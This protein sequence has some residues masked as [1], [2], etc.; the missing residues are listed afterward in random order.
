L[1]WL[2]EVAAAL[3]TLIQTDL[4]VEVRVDTELARHNLLSLDL[5]TQSQ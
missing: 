1:W 3:E 2:V 5:L 4:V